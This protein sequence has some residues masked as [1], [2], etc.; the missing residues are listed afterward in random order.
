MPSDLQNE[1][2][3]PPLL[4][5]LI[6]GQ[7]PDWQAAEHERPRT[8]AESLVSLLSVHPNDFDTF[9]FF[10]LLLGYDQVGADPAQDG[11]CVFHRPV[12]R[13]YTKRTCTVQ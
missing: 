10:E 8:E 7:A 5:E 12:W 1:V 9:D 13:T 6:R 3:V 2:P 11:A 4:E